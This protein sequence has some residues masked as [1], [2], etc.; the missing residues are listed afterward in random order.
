MKRVIGTICIFIMVL[1]LV[2]CGKERMPIF[3]TDAE[4]FKYEYESVN[5]T[6]DDNGMKARTLTVPSNNSVIYASYSEII[7]LM[8]Q[9]DS[10]AVYFGF[11]KCPWCRACL[12]AILES[13]ADCAVSPLYY[14]D[15]HT[16]RDTYELKNGKAV[17]TEEGEEGYARLLPKFENVLSDYIIYDADENEIQT[18]EK[19]IYAPNLIIVKDGTAVKLADDNGLLD[20]PYGDVTEEVYQK[21]KKIY[22]DAF[23]MLQ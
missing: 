11:A 6:R 5:G 7:D 10:F 1:L 19:R 18:G 17:K 9:G 2:G 3:T 20:N 14:V 8:E 4:R 21:M 15:V 22:T 23:L 12:E 16:S 13:A